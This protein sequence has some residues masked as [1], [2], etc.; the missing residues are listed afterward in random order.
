MVKT[1]TIFK[2]FNETRSINLT[3]RIKKLMYVTEI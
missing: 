1:K 3:R 2:V